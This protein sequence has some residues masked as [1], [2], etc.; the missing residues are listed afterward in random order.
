MYDNDNVTYR[1]GINWKDIILKIIILALFILF[2]IWLFPKA[3]LDVF[4]DNVYTNN[5]KTM[6]EAAR[7]YYTV[8][9]LPKNVGDKQSMTL[10]EMVD[11]H[12]LVRFTD[13]DG[14][15]CDENNSKVEVTKLSDN[16][17][18]LKVQL[19]CGEQNDYVLETIGC[20]NICS[21]GTCTTIINNNG[22]NIAN[23]TPNNSNTPNTNIDN[24]NGT[25]NG[26]GSK[27]ELDE[28]I[29]TGDPKNPGYS[30]TVTLYQHRQAI[31]TTKTVYTCPAGYTKNGSKC[32]KN[33]T[34]ATIDATPV[35]N[36]DQV[37]TTDAK[38]HN[39]GTY[40][41]Y[42]DP[43]KTEVGTEYSCP[44]GYTKNGT[45]CIKYTDA[46]AHLGDITYTCPSGYTLRNNDCVRTYTASASYTSGSYTCPQGGSLNGTTCTLTQSATSHTDTSYSCPTGYNRNGTKCTKTYTASYSGGNTTYTCPQGGT[47]N[48]SICTMT[49]TPTATTTYTCPS[50]YSKNGSSCY[51]VYNAKAT[52]TYSCPAGY[53]PSGSQCYKAATPSSSTGAWVNKGTQY[54]SSANKAYTGSTSKLVYVGAVSGAVCGSPCGNKGIWYKY[55]YYTRSSTTTYSCPSGTT[56]DGS[57]CYINATPKTSYTCPQGGTPN[58]NV[59]TLSASPTPSTTYSCP[60]GYT[61]SGSSCIKTYNATPNTTQGNYTCPQ[62]GTR[63]GNICTITQDAYRSSSTYYSCPSG[64]TKN[65]TICTKTYTGTYV[66]GQ[67]VYTCPQ[68][69]TL[70]GNV[71]T[72]TTTPTARRGETT[73]TCPT[74]YNYNS[75]TGKCEYKINAYAEKVY[76]YSCPTGYTKSGEGENTRCSKVVQGENIYYC[77]DAAAKLEGTKCIKTIRGTIKN[78]TCPTG[79]TLNGTKCTKKTTV[80]IDATVST[81]T[82]TSYKYKWS[83]KSELDGWEFTGKTKTQTKNY[84]AGQK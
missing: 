72:V 56:R 78:Y 35:Y 20:T 5:I 4:Y 31:T 60:S 7:N 39:T 80:T 75:A 1:V 18:S 19:N 3:N 21:N 64:Y 44:T 46:T 76:E 61:Q 52:T 8:D 65:G 45:Y 59:C 53:T 83:E 54:Y 22:S 25:N 23:N 67:T 16:E 37:L 68:G 24:G 58:G 41:V 6:K 26:N 29:Y 82:S 27:T 34:G 62:G 17:Y 77:E 43:I 69:G 63:N 84:S 36:P 51:K 81:K 13:K 2:L 66:S 30:V 70:N 73:Y 11:N 12:M 14:Q 10:K 79:Y 38:Y 49:T 55:T 42:A 48:G 50:G 40:T 33:T 28:T 9:K 57:N 71:C 74:G 32:L 15:T 47:P